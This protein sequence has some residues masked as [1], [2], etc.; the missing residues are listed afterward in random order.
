MG[1]SR[2]SRSP[3]KT[4][5]H[6]ARRVPDRPT[7]AAVEATRQRGR[8][9]VRTLRLPR[10]HGMRRV[11][12]GTRI[13]G[14]SCMWAIGGVR[15]G[16]AMGADHCGQ[17]TWP[18]AAESG[19]MQARCGGADLKTTRAATPRRQPATELVGR[20]ERA[21]QCD[22]PYLWLHAMR[23]AFGAARYGADSSP[24]ATF[25]QCTESA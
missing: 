2:N 11:R 21:G 20:L 24:S 7:V 10:H 9:R 6:G 16:V 17:R 14:I 19:Q 22:P 4:T 5:S 3:T 25:V 1:V 18:E 8:Q 15:F 13:H 23:Q 12:Q